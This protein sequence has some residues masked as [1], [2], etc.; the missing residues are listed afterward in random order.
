MMEDKTKV[1][2]IGLV[3]WAE[4][5]PYAIH[6]S[7][8]W[9]FLDCTA[10]T[11]AACQSLIKKQKRRAY[12][13][14]V[15]SDELDN[16]L[17]EELSPLIETYTLIIDQHFQSQ[18]STQ[19]QNTKFPVYLSFDNPNFICETVYQ[20]FFSGQSGGKL[21]VNE[22]EINNF[23]EGDMQFL[24]EH[25]LSVS[26]DF[27][28][29]GNKP[30]ITWQYNRGFYERS[31]KIWLEF[32]RSDNA[33]FSLVVHGFRDNTT[34]VMKIWRFTESEV[35][36]GMELPY[37]E[38]LGF[39]SVSLW[40]RGYGNIKVGPLH[41]RDTRGPYGEYLPG[42][43][44]V[45]DAQNEELDY[46]FHPGDLK[47]P[48]AVYFS[49]YRSLEGF[50]GFYMM[51][52]MGTPFLLIADPRLEGGSFYL[53]S[54]Q[55]E[56]SIRDVIQTHLN[57]LGFSNQ[58]LIL[59]GLSMGT[60]GALYHGSFLHPHSIIVG[61]PLVNLGTMAEKE[62]IIRPGGFPTS[63]DLLQSLTGRQDKE[64]IQA[65]NHRFWSTFDAANFSDTQFVMAYMKD[66]DYDDTAY[67]DVLE[68]LL[69]KETRVIGKGIS[70]RHND[71]SEAIN[72]WFINHYRRI[73]DEDFYRGG[74]HAI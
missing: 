68:H 69:T 47:P 6:E 34:D 31:K 45:S 19:I 21:H 59:S 37:E 12:N 17:L 57:S 15:V 30:L 66:D 52:K 29:F 24:G 33:S 48:L 1:L 72:Q 60:F 22:A 13:V 50:E 26:G 11:E 64:G 58:E 25:R 63:L 46:F 18:V 35:R 38:G 74:E 41:F 40:P 20:C 3:N 73:L 36:A 51:K 32:T 39:V 49:G 10:T 42:G 44:K 4:V 55:L 8:E 62:R 23:F 14:V 16:K 5:F 7:I 70:G 43:K 53:G 67:Q 27:T 65:L 61:K 28:S 9:Q 71:N 2:Q 54:E 56:T